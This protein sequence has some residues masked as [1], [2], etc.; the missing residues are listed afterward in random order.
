MDKVNIQRLADELN[1]SIATVSRALRDSYQIRPETRKKVWDLARKLNYQPNPFASGLREQKSNN[2]AVIF[3]ELANNFFS[4]AINGIEEIARQK[5]YQVLIYLTHESA[6][7]EIGFVNS[8][9]SGRVD[10][11]LLSLSSET[12]DYEH[13]IALN[14]RL[15]VLLFDRV[16][17]SGDMLHVSTNDYE[18]SYQGTMHLVEKGCRKIAYLLALKHLVPGRK[19]LEGYKD[20]LLHAGLPVDP[21]LILDCD[22]TEKENYEV[23]SGAMQ[24]LQPDGILSSIE[25]LG[26]LCY[27]VAND[28]GISIGG[29]VKIV[30][31]SNLE[32]AS[33][34]Q[35]SLT[36]ITQPAFEIGREAAN[37]LFQMLDKKKTVTE[38]KIIN[39]VLIE[40]ASTAG[41]H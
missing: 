24:A 32:T 30:S 16:C 23:I 22:G 36:T 31:F 15:P 1:L 6:E 21:S 18:S 10:G 19:R 41:V 38:S 17:D 9:A 14:K 33:L 12:E 40:R 20:A 35:P 27:Y 13:I 25:K 2:I 4:L 34:L 11:L 8:L 29:K 5:N 37:T 28:A 3:P 26:T 39:S 7:R